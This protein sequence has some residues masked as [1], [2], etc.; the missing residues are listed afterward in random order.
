MTTLYAPDPITLAPGVFVVFEG[1]DGCGKST[2]AKLLVNWLREN[3][4][5][6]V[7]A[8]REPGATTIGSKIRDLVLSPDN[9]IDPRA[10]AMLFAADRAQHVAEVVRPALERGAIVVSDRYM[11]SS[12]AYQGVGRPLDPADI[13]VLSGWATH[14]LVPHLTIVLDVDERVSQARRDAD[15]DR[16]NDRMEQLPPDFHARV[17]QGFLARAAQAPERYFVLDAN[18]PID[19]LHEKIRTKC[20]EA[21]L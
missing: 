3:T 14:G 7:I 2:Q 17:R 20:R 4:S 1:G 11:D 6:E 15:P 10:E 13:T 16:L 19:V 21:I 18:A 9:S 5:H 12:I 8:T